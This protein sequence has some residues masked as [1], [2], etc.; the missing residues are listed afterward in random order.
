[1]GAETNTTEYLRSQLKVTGAEL[2]KLKKFLIE[3][4][5]ED[6]ELGSEA[7][8]NTILAFRHV[9]DAAMRLGKVLQAVNG[10]VSIYD[11][12]GVVEQK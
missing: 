11:N 10:G 2:L 3:H 12:S 5:L 9:E 8:A 4:P 1:M 7:I 6:R